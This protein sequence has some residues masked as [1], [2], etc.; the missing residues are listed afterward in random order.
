MPHPRDPVPAPTSQPM[1]VPAPLHSAP[2]PV[3]PAIPEIARGA[4][5][6]ALPA[7][8]HQISPPHPSRS[9]LLK[10]PAAGKTHS[11]KT[12]VFPAS[13]AARGLP[14]P[15]RRRFSPTTATL[16]P[17]ATPLHCPCCHRA[18]PALPASPSTASILAQSVPET[19]SDQPPPSP[20]AASKFRSPDDARVRRSLRPSRLSPR[21]AGKSVSPA[22]YLPAPDFPTLSAPGPDFSN[23]QCPRPA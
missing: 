20:P 14:S 16:H 18:P 15:S 13:G 4:T 21:L 17:R 19:F 3:S 1:R 6:S 12:P 8:A 10:T 5:R 2:D 11:R 9:P 22:P 23:I 7:T